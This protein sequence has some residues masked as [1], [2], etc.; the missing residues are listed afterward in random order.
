MLERERERERD[1]V[2]AAVWK[3]E[4]K[5]LTHFWLKK[6]GPLESVHIN[7][8]GGRLC[9]YIARTNHAAAAA[10]HRLGGLAHQAATL[11]HSLILIP[12]TQPKGLH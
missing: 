8:L 9:S 12:A 11:L 10:V 7:L 1:G 4:D 6:F 5:V 2:M 3:V